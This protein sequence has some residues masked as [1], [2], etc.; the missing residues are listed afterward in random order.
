MLYMLDLRDLKAYDLQGLSP[1]AVAVLAQQMLQHIEQQAGELQQKDRESRP[2]S[3]CTA[4]STA[5]GPAAA[6]KC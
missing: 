2:S 1:E 5:S 4:T 6:A 3:S